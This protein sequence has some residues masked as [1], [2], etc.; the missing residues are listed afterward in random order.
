VIAAC[1]LLYSLLSAP[2]AFAQAAVIGVMAI[3]SPDTGWVYWD[4]VFGG[5]LR[6]LGYNVGQSLIIE[7]RWAHGDIGRYPQLARE[8]MERRPALIVAPCGPSLRAIREIT[9]T[10][11]VIANCADEKNFLGEVASLSRPGGYTTGITFLSPES[12]GKRLELLREILPGL[13]RLAILYQPSDPI[14]AHWRELER[15]QPMLGLALQRLPLERAEELE[16]AFAAIVRERAQ[17]LFVFPANRMIAERVRIAELARRHQIATVFESAIH[18]DAGGL[19]SYGGSIGEWL[20][21]TAPMYVDKILKGTK[22]GELPIVQPTQFELV[23]NLT[24]A[25]ALG[26]SIPR[27]LL[28]RADRVIE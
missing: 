27:S 8:L 7:Y 2:L 16:A 22:P 20:G 10:L 19:L 9:R 23:V 24:T 4:Q 15:L 3:G 18:V 11:P 5:G 12:V 6:K 1:A 13:T 28:N 14:P 17:A 21:K 25:R 26:I